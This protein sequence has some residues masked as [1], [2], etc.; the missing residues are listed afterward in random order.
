MQDVSRETREKLTAYAAMI[1]K[2]NK[3]INLIGGSTIDDIKERHIADSLQLCRLLPRTQSSIADFG[4]G[5]G[6]PGVVLSI[7]IP[8]AKV[9]LVESDKRK[10]AFLRQAKA[11]V[12]LDCLI[13]SERIESLAPLSADVICARALAPLERLLDLSFNHLASGGTLLFPKGAT[14]DEE[15]IVARKHWDFDCEKIPSTT[16]PTASILKI[17][18]LKRAN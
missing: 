9:T 10:A 1:E 5:A 2:W 16:D 12:R 18:N 14:V 13:I 6:L 7:A 4:S 3:S 15:I 11:A 17:E 8:E